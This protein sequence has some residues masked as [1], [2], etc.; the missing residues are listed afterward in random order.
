MAR[1]HYWQFIINQE[2]QPINNAEVS[3]YLA[4]TDTPAYVYSSEFGGNAINTTPQAMTNRAGYFEFWLGDDQ[5]SD[6]YPIGQKFKLQWEREGVASGSIDWLDIF[7]G[8]QPVDETSPDSNLKNRLISDEL[9]HRWNSHAIHSV[10]NQGFPIHGLER[11]DPEKDDNLYNKVVNN[12]LI[13]ELMEHKEDAIDHSDLIV[14]VEGILSGGGVLTG[15]ITISLLNENITH[16]EVSGLQGGSITQRYHL[17]QSQHINLTNNTPSFNNV[18]LTGEALLPD[19][20]IKKDY[21]DNIAQGIYWQNS[22]IEF[23]DVEDLGFPDNPFDSDG[24]VDL[25]DGDRYI[26]MGTLTDGPNSWQENYIYEWSV[27]QG[28]IEITPEKGY[29]LLVEEENRHYHYD[30]TEWIKF[31]AGFA[32]YLVTSSSVVSNRCGYLVDCRDGE[33][34]LLFPEN[35]SLGYRIDVLDFTNS[36][37]INNIILDGNGDLIEGQP[38]FDIDVNGAGVQLVYTTPEFGWKVINEVYT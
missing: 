26:S 24:I 2:G 33:V 20:A 9:G 23:W 11:V 32:W 17:N 14:D 12:V 28:W 21:V 7:P 34:T 4:G 10:T 25:E 18:I 35:P 15:P 37:A 38:T 5:E 31:W 13:K 1:Y 6:G 27:V 30:G 19:H 16:N 8:F 3:L 29:T 22:V 36:S